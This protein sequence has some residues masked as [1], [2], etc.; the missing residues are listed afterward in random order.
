MSTALP[1]F[2]ITFTPDGREVYFN[3]ASARRDTLTIMVSRAVNGGWTMATVAPFSGRYRDVDPFVTPD[4]NRLFFSST[5][6]RAG[7]R[8]NS[9]NTWYVE[10]R[11]NGWSEPIDPGAPLNTDST[12]VF[13]SVAR[14]GSVAFQSNR[15]G[16]MRIWL[17]RA[18]ATGWA[19]PRVVLFGGFAAGGNPLMGPDGQFMVLV[20]DG[21]ADRSDLFVSC[22][23]GEVWSE[24]VVLPGV[25]SRY[26][27][28][29]P[30]LDPTGHTL[31]FTSERPGILPAQPDSI[32][33]PGDIYR[34]PLPQLPQGCN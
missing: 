20:R 27:E 32:R 13:V 25:N 21:P 5:R 15:G 7:D 29:A 16:A 6:P 3:R 23:A 9:L 22:A 24:P 28:F 31:Y 34:V 30:A 14:D 18:T 1:E 26:A 17:A 10:R 12:E 19:E 33:P 11:G 4:G 2:A 8:V